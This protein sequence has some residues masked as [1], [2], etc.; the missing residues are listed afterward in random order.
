[1][2][3]EYFAEHARTALRDNQPDAAIR[4]A[5]RGLETEKRNPFL[6]QYLASAKLTR[7]DSLP[8]AGER[9]TC[10]EDALSALS[11]AR[12]LAPSDRTFLVPLA[13]TYDAL[14]RF[15]EAEW[16]FY[17]ARRWDPRSIYLNEIYKYHLYRWRASQ[18]SPAAEQSPMQKQ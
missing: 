2:P 1:L 14:D 8:D 12:E 11:K 7:C 6:Y 16:I 13:A 4:F 18:S 17:E 3:G 5:L 10:Y 9:A 15:A